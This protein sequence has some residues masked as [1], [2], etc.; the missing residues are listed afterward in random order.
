MIERHMAGPLRAAL[1]DT[2]VVF[3]VGARQAGKTTLARGLRRSGKKARYL[4]LDEPA[5][6]T[7]ARAD[8]AAFLEDLDGPVILDEVQ[9]APALFPVLRAVVDRNR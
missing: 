6:L 7:S 2:P 4:S 8:P 3:L 5:V 1:S 9:Q